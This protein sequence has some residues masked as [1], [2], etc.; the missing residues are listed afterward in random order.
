MSIL[1]NS[2][3]QICDAFDEGAMS[4]DSREDTFRQLSVEGS[5]RMDAFVF[6]QLFREHLQKIASLSAGLCFSFGW[7]IGY[8]RFGNSAFWFRLEDETN[9]WNSCD[10]KI[11]SKLEVFFCDPKRKVKTRCFKVLRD[12]SSLI[13]YE[14]TDS[15][16]VGPKF[17]SK[18][19][20]DLPDIVESTVRDM[21][22]IDG[23]ASALAIQRLRERRIAST[24]PALSVQRRFMNCMLRRYLGREGTD[25]DAVV[26]APDGELRYIEFKRKF[27]AP[28]AKI[29][30]LD[31]YPHVKT[32]R[33]L[34]SLGIGMLHL[35]L[36]NPIWDK[37]KP[38]L[39]MI[40]PELEDKWAWLIANLN[41]D[42]FTGESL[43]TVGKDSG[44]RNG[45]RTQM[46]IRWDCMHLLHSGLALGN[47][48]RE[49]LADAISTGSLLKLPRI[50]YAGLCNVT[51]ER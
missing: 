34:A 28:R 4:H 23:D 26:L 47:A 27:P 5:K 20:S 32:M 49:K 10:E 24:L 36:V 2:M 13:A 19:L 35:I 3:K 16:W 9:P 14:W 45:N 22:N 50:N 25:L 48:G 51:I 7:H 15:K 46:Q 33:T 21:D 6:E 37:S 38:P 29:F 42:A 30:G 31:E 17:L 11:L 43:Q 18:V 44:Q 39:G 8:N 1:V 41:G 12:R 40:V